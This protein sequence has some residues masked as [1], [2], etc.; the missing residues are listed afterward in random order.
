MFHWATKE[1]YMLWFY[2]RVGRSKRIEVLLPRLVE[3]GKLVARRHGKRLIYSIP[4]KGLKKYRDLYQPNIAHELAC[5]EGLVRI[6]LSKPDCE[7]IPTGRFFGFG[8][9]PEWGIRYP[10]GKLLLYEFCTE[11]NFLRKLK[12]KVARYKE[13]LPEIETKFDCPAIAVFV[14]DVK[15]D[16][17]K[18]WVDRN[19]LS[20]FP[21]FFTDYKTFLGVPLKQQLATEIYIWGG[22]G[23]PHPLENARLSSS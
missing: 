4:R 3:Q 20:G 23:K 12:G 16:L 1:H 22:D 10:S 5:T 11:D 6:M 14:L 17:V 13:V 21:F 2:G 15:R 19:A 8:V 7:V 9:V 18:S